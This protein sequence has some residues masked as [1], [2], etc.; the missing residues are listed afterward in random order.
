[1]P[2]TP[3]LLFFVMFMI[4]FI[5]FLWIPITWLSLSILTP[6]PLLDRYFKEPHFT[7]TETY[8]L[9]EFPG[10]L[11]RTAIW[12]WALVWPSR[13]RARKIKNVRDYMPLWYAIGLR[14]YIWGTLA[15]GFIM[16]SIM[17]FLFLLPESVSKDYVFFN[18][19]WPFDW[20]PLDNVERISEKS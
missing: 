10:F 7:L 19:P 5:G 14:I 2:V 11:M 18:L 4:I 12:G 17:S 16:I 20:H 6:K 15:T 3:E 8:M 1:M 9:K 13:D